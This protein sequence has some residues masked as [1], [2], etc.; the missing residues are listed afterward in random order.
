ME[1]ERESGFKQLLAK[2]MPTIRYAGKRILT[3]LPVALGI[4]FI[5]FMVIEQMPGDPAAA[6]MDP[7]K[8]WD[9]DLYI[10]IQRQLGVDGPLHIK[11]F[12]WLTNLA[13]G[14]FG[15]ST[16]FGGQPIGPHIATAIGNTFRVNLV[17]YIIA[18]ALALVI[19]IKAAVDRRS[20]FDNFW[21]VFSLIGIS[22]PSFFFAMILIFVFVINLGW[23]PFNGMISPNL[24]KDATQWMIY[25][26]MAY[27]MVLPVTV[28]ALT[29]LPGLFRYIRNSMLEVLN[30]DYIRT[31]RSK[32]LKDKVVIYRH[33]FRNALIP[34]VTVVGSMIPGLFSGSVIVEGIFVYP[35]IGQLL[36]RAINMRDRN[37]VVVLLVFFA[38][39][40]LL[41][42]LL[43]D[44]TYSLVDPRI[45]V[46]E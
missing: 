27:H 23:L 1:K 35:G 42:N 37:V 17:G 40:Q 30:Q 14:N 15:Y 5:L 4:A 45:R 8:P 38:V 19:G 24:P 22:M 39:L 25:K 9:Q 6:L 41:A 16:M 13:K 11:F 20:F 33:A 44:L 34:I 12:R 21:T 2:S 36:I 28:V 3:L 10:A 7:E 43:V 29:S 31:A 26:N 18:L 46:G 32:G